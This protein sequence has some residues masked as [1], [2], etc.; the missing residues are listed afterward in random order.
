MKRELFTE[1][2]VVKLPQVW[3]DRLA[4]EAARVPTTESELARQAIIASLR[5]KHER[6]KRDTA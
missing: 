4:A 1:R 5:D 6:A 2:L 3:K